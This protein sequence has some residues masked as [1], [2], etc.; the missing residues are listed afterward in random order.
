M[1]RLKNVVFLTRFWNW[2]LFSGGHLNKRKATK[3]C[4]EKKWSW[5]SLHFLTWRSNGSWQVH[6]NFSIFFFFSFFEKRRKFWNLISCEIFLKNTFFTLLYPVILLAEK[7]KKNKAKKSIRF[8][9]GWSNRI[10]F[11]AL[12]FL[13]FFF[14]RPFFDS[15]DPL[16]RFL[17]NFS[18]RSRSFW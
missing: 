17:S 14:F 16:R 5:I 9:R 15:I 10:D 12:F 13:C 7:K 11:F 1:F 2:T 3:E 6:S 4:F 18:K 8:G